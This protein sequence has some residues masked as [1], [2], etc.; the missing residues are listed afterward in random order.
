[1]DVTHIGDSNLG[2]IWS[3]LQLHH[4]RTSSGERRRGRRP[5]QWRWA[6]A[7]AIPKRPGRAGQIGDSLFVLVEGSPA[8]IL[9]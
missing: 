9:L 7:K 8:R 6:M 2:T 3:T 5:R 1:M 4:A